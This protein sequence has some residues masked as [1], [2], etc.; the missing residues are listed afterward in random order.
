VLPLQET[1]GDISERLL[2]R[3][4]LHCNSFD[5][6]LKNIYPELHVPEDR[7]GWHGAVSACYLYS[8]IPLVTFKVQH[9]CFI[10]TDRRAAR[11]LKSK[12]E[13]RCSCIL[14]FPVPFTGSLNLSGRLEQTWGN[15]L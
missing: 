9:E 11:S 1:Y 10:H 12:R 7:K 5:W 3:E 15:P 13:R 4:R 2:L 6:Y 14:L 8:I